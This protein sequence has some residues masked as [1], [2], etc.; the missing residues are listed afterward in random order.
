MKARHKPTIRPASRPPKLTQIRDVDHGQAWAVILG[1]ATL[2]AV[3]KLAWYVPN[4]R[5]RAA[6]LGVPVPGPNP[7]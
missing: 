1:A 4:L 6:A 3:A 2:I 7:E 5:T